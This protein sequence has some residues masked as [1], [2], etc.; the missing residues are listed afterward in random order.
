MNSSLYKTKVIN[1]SIT[2]YC[3]TITQKWEKKKNND[4]LKE[5]IIDLQNGTSWSKADWEEICNQKSIASF[6]DL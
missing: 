2:P 6:Y 4:S 1:D 5:C 3:F